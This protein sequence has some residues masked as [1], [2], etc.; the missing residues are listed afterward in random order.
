MGWFDIK[1]VIVLNSGGW[2]AVKKP[3]PVA[4]VMPAEEIDRLD[5]E[6]LSGM[7]REALAVMRKKL[8]LTMDELYP[9]CDP[10]TPAWDLWER[11]FDKLDA[12]V[13]RIDEILDDE[14]FDNDQEDW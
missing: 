14:D 6:S 12:M 4:G 2:P 3:K 7:N 9:D 8:R 10:G 1:P 5:P 11:R 13:D